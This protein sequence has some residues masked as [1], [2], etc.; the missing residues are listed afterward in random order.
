[1]QATRVTALRTGVSLEIL[2]A[3]AASAWG[4]RPHW[5]VCDEL[6]NWADVPNS[7]NFYTSC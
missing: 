3:D 1:M 2:A 5:L 7:R 4:L 6:A